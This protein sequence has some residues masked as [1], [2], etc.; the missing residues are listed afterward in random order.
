[1]E[2]FLQG[3]ALWYYIR[4]HTKI[5]EETVKMFR[6]IIIFSVDAHHIF[7][8]LRQ[9]PHNQWL[10]M[11]F[12]L[13]VEEIDQLFRTGPKNGDNLSQRIKSL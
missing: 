6:N 10:A 3:E 11:Q 2:F 5:T 4:K 12:Q 1:M 7:L 8:H 9:D 13:S